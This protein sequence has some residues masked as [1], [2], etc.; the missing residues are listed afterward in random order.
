MALNAVEE[1]ASAVRAWLAESNAAVV[2]KMSFMNA[3]IL[4]STAFVLIVF[5]DRQPKWCS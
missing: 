1:E 2:G 5:C 4:V 3:S